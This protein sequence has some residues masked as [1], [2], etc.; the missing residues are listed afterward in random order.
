MEVMGFVADRK[1][2]STV[3]FRSDCKE[4]REDLMS[5]GEIK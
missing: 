4:L 5:K 3:T 2:L 1:L